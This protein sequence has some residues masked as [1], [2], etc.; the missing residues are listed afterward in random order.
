MVSIEVFTFLIDF[1][2]QSSFRFPEKLSETSYR[3]PVSP[4]PLH[5]HSCSWIH[6]ATPGI[7]FQRDTFVTIDQ[8]ALN[9]HDACQS[10]QFTSGFTLGVIYCMGFETCTMTC[11][12]HYTIM[13]SIFIV[14][15]I[16]FALPFYLF[17][18][19]TLATTYLFT[20]SIVLPFPEC[21]IIVRS[22][23]RQTFALQYAFKIPLRF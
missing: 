6:T 20:D 3:T 19:V 15:K 12:Y 1:V 9:H 23:F 11:M 17:L 8:L 16:L 7:P 5:L 10:A 2:Y 18:P 22:I 13:K 4:L 14:L 21:C